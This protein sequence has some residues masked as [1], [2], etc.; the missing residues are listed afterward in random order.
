MEASEWNSDA[1][2]QVQGVLETAITTRRPFS[3]FDAMVFVIAAAIGF[4]MARPHFDYIRGRLTLPSSVPSDIRWQK[5][6]RDFNTYGNEI[7]LYATVLYPSITMVVV[8]NL[9]FALRRPR[10]PVREV[11]KQPGIAACLAITAAVLIN[12]LRLAPEAIVM[13]LDGRFKLWSLNLWSRLFY[14]NSFAVVGAWL[15]LL[16]IGGWRPE[17]EWTGRVGRCFGWC[18]ILSLIFESMCSWAWLIAR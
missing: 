13:I 12:C 2:H 6:L 15:I 7:R 4:A 8:V 17:R 10:P 9:C 1:D 14:E 18:A 11:F 3:L 16:A 5:I